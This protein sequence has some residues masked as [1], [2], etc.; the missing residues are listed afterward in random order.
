MTERSP[1]EVI[2]FYSYKGGVGRSMA[3]ANV[4]TLLAQRGKRV[5]ALDFDLEAPGL[6]R[7]FGSAPATGREPGGGVI[8]FFGELR[9]RLSAAPPAQAAEEAPAAS[10]PDVTTEERLEEEARAAIA[11]L[12]DGGKFLRRVTV[13]NPNDGSQ[14]TLSLMQAGRFDERYPERVRSFPWQT[15]YEEHPFFVEILAEQLGDRFD[16]V[17]IDSRTGT[18]DVGNL[19]TVLMPEKLVLVSTPNEQSLHGAIEVGRQAVELR[20]ESSDLRPLP[21]F[22]LVSRVENAEDALQREWIAKARTRYEEVFRTAYGI[23]KDLSTYFDTIQIPHRSFYAYGEVIAAE[24]ERITEARSLAAAFREFSDALQCNNAVD[25]QTAMRARLV[26]P[27]AAQT[28]AAVA[29]TQAKILTEKVVA[30]EVREQALQQKLKYLKQDS[31]PPA[32]ATTARPE[33]PAVRS[34]SALWWVILVA[35]IGATGMLASF[36]MVR[37]EKAQMSPPAS[38]GESAAVGKIAPAGPDLP[39]EPPPPIATSPP[40]AM[41]VASPASTASTSKGIRSPTSPKPPPV[42][43]TVDQALLEGIQPRANATPGNAVTKSGKP[44]YRF[45]VWIDTTPEIAKG[46]DSVEYFFDHPSFEVNRFTSRQGPKFLQS[47]S[48]WGCLPHVLVTIKSK[49]GSSGKID[50]NQCGAI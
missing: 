6:H 40:P 13:N 1:G 38:F 30:A 25:A 34:R 27:S 49:D 33:A 48:G 7:Y 20:K 47:Y 16:Y 35:G 43:P 9:S 11:D 26:A 4:A 22:P 45:E 31:E 21:L 18:T 50:F 17:L 37:S 3:L 2:T 36:L 46:I 42:T 14:V 39:T 12:L 10:A 29:E 32:A 19:C 44:V 15:F 41:S 8:E 24:R 5:L 23:T 28:R